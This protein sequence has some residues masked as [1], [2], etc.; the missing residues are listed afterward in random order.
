M[1]KEIFYAVAV[2]RQQ[3]LF[4]NLQEAKAQ[5]SKFPKGRYRKFVSRDSAEEYLEKAGVLPRRERFYA[6]SNGRKI[7]LFKNKAEA[8]A[9]IFEYSYSSMKKFFSR[10]D[11][12]NNPL[13]KKSFEKN[14]KKEEKKLKK[15]QE[16]LGINSDNESYYES[17]EPDDFCCYYVDSDEYGFGFGINDSDESDEIYYDTSNGGYRFNGYTHFFN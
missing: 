13:F 11:A 5:V 1:P 16:S 4:K 3:G 7:G 14:K 17:S 15:L 2:G 6:V 12:I 8:N 9:Q 10:E